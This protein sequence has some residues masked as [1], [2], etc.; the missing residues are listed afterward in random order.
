M[1]RV[2]QV[3][4]RGLRLAYFLVVRL[5]A[6]QRSFKRAY[7]D[8]NRHHT[9][10]VSAALSYYFILSAFPGLILLSAVMGFIPLPALFNHV[11]TLMAR[12]L[13]AEAMSLVYTV[14]PDVLG[15]HRA[16]WLSLG[17][18][19]TIWMSSSGFDALIEAL[20]IAYDAK[21]D[22]AYWKTRLL[23]VGLAAITGGLLLVA[24]VVTVLGPRFGD[25]LGTRVRISNA[26][27]GIWPALHWTIAIGFTVLAVEVVY[28]LAPNVKQRFL[29]TLPG[30][31]LAVT[32]WNALSYL[33]GLYFRHFADYNRT[34]GTLGG[35]IAM[36]T[37]LYWTSFVLLVGAEL[38]AELAKE[39][40]KGSLESKAAPS[41]AEP[42]PRTDVDQAA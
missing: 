25:W 18:I 6:I 19:G 24:L 39:S 8:L 31:I 29:A 27:A 34:Y 23:A 16:Q 11:L 21:D 35:V 10:Q 4:R 42:I 9:L 13:P 15:S 40:K 5:S 20:D 1:N 14:L 30:A 33:L 36:M 7:D 41:K 38:N 3:F 17:M 37:W 28:F 2:F 32:V 12:L 26:F 22:R